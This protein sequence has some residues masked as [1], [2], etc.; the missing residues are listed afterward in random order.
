MIIF[1]KVLGIHNRKGVAS[2]PS[3]YELDRSLVPNFELATRAE[4][5]EAAPIKICRFVG[6]TEILPRNRKKHDFLVK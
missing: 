6:F 2:E 4:A 1:T 5:R 3:I